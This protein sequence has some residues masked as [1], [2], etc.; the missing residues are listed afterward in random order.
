MGER[1]SSAAASFV[2]RRNVESG[3]PR[4]G[5][6]FLYPAATQCRR[7]NPIIKIDELDR[8]YSFY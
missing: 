6:A 7:R 2:A 5:G 3:M 8:K 4:A 1:L